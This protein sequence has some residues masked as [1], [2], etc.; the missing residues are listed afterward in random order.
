LVWKS[1]ETIS[2]VSINNVFK[3]GADIVR[4]KIFGRDISRLL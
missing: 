2:Q 4:T 1:F 3:V